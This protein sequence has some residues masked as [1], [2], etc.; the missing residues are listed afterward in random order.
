[1]LL[2]TLDASSGAIDGAWWP[3]T[4]Y[5]SGELHDLI[6]VLKPRLGRLA[7]VVFDW[8]SGECI[9]CGIMHLYGVHGVRLALLV[10]PADTAPELATQRMRWATGQ[11]LPVDQV[12]ELIPR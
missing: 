6:T 11:P 9:D 2:R 12:P 10:I 8:K 4:A 5:P 1:M 7:R 3:R